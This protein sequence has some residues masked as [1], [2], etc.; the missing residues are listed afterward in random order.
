MKTWFLWLAA[1]SSTTTKSDFS[2]ELSTA[3][4]ITAIESP[5]FYTMLDWFEVART[6]GIVNNPPVEED[7]S[8]SYIPRRS[9]YSRIGMAVLGFWKKCEYH[10]AYF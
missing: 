8:L 5:S 3:T 9:A 4:D 10:F 2:F 7:L 1:C 6:P